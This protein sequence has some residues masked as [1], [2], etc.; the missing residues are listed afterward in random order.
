MGS[1]AEVALLEEHIAILQEARDD[2]EAAE[3]AEFQKRRSLEHRLF[4]AEKESQMLKLQLAR[5][6][7]QVEELESQLQRASARVNDLHETVVRAP[8]EVCARITAPQAA[9]TDPSASS[10]AVPLADWSY[11]RFSIQMRERETQC[12]FDHV[13]LPNETNA[14]V[15]HV[16]G[17]RRLVQTLTGNVHFTYYGYGDDRGSAAATLVQGPPGDPSL[18][19][20]CVE[21]AV[22]TYKMT[23][24]LVC[25]EQVGGTFYELGA[26]PRRDLGVALESASSGIVARCAGSVHRS[27]STVMEHVRRAEDQRELHG[28]AWYRLTFDDEAVRMRLGSVS[29]VLFSGIRKHLPSKGLLLGPRYSPFVKSTAT[30]HTLADLFPSL[31]VRNGNNLVMLPNH[32][33][34]LLIN[35]RI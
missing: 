2:A 35:S 32:L 11:D 19:E 13:F 23:L 34:G 9:T 3:A 30:E 5:R 6:S 20:R 8:L 26:G 31:R 17:Q 7:L 14:H 21:Y 24:N 29:F 25:I 28:H 15:F 27:T 10:D 12:A 22:Q 16:Y 33:L 18:L 4:E 1:A